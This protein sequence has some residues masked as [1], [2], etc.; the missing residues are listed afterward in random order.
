MRPERQAEG[1]MD[2]VICGITVTSAATYRMHIEGAKHLKK[3]RHEQKKKEALQKQKN[4]QVR[5]VSKYSCAKK[6]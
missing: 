5:G 1:T 3:V 6:K 4:M 2:C